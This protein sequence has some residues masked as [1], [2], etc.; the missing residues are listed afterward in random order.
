[1]K[2]VLE[3]LRDDA[4]YYGGVGKNYLSNSDIQSLLGNVKEF[5]VPRAD[6][7]VFAKG[8]L[9]HQLILEPEKASEVVSLDIGSRN[10]F[11]TC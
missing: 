8:R 3:K 11:G 7:P 6:N 2:D 10:K 4:E 5:R 9:F 1:M